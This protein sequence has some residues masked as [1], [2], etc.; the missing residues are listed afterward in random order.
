VTET[1][2]PGETYQEWMLAQLDAL[3]RALQAK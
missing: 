3:D 2:P 1:K